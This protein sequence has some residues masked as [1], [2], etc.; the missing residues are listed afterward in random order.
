ME[1]SKFHFQVME[2]RVGGG[3]GLGTSLVSLCKT[4][5]SKQPSTGPSKLAKPTNMN[6]STNSDKQ[7]LKPL[8]THISLACA[9]SIPCWNMF[10]DQPSQH[11]D[12][13][14]L[15]ATICKDILLSPSQY[16]HHVGKGSTQ[17][18]RNIFLQPSARTYWFSQ[19]STCTM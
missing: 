19:V 10:L 18:L 11:M 16:M 12:K 6:L 9:H 7:A 14:H 13:E 1:T 17:A 5:G 3:W 4:K 8:C 2:D 15:S